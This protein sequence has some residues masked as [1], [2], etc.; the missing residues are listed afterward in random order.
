M[1]DGQI[2]LRVDSSSDLYTLPLGLVIPYAKSFLACQVKV[3]PTSSIV[4]SVI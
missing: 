2:L 4:V 3:K 1:K